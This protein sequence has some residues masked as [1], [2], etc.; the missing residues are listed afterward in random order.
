VIVL[1]HELAG[2]LAADDL[3]EE[4]VVHRLSAQAKACALRCQ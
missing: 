4:T 3:A 2:N 1:V